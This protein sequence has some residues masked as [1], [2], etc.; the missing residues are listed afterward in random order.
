[1]YKRGSQAKR[2]QI[3]HL[4]S[5][6]RAER[7][8]ATPDWLF[9]FVG[10]DVVRA[11]LAASFL[12]V[13]Y[14]QEEACGFTS[15]WGFI[16]AFLRWKCAVLQAKAHPSA[17]GPKERKHPVGGIV[18]CDCPLVLCEDGCSFIEN[19]WPDVVIVPEDKSPPGEGGRVLFHKVYAASQKCRPPIDSSLSTEP[20]NYWPCCA[21][22]PWD[23]DSFLWRAEP[24]CHRYVLTTSS[25]GHPPPAVDAGGV[26]TPSFFFET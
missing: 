6:H 11:R 2:H 4:R 26:R 3:V 13:A 1:M 8:G 5:P 25:I 7:H 16:K 24:S 19:R 22:Y 9:L 15:T 14:A 18:V 23:T 20:Q 10:S 21:L 17:N 12:N